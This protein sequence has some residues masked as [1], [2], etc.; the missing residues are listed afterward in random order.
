[1]IILKIKKKDQTKKEKSKIKKINTDNLFRFYDFNKEEFD[2]TYLIT[3]YIIEYVFKKQTEY[4]MSI[5]NWKQQLKHLL[6]FLRD[7]EIY[8]NVD[9]IYSQD[10]NFQIRS[11]GSIILGYSMARI[12]DKKEE[13]I[14]F[15]KELIGNELDTSK[16]ELEKIIFR[17]E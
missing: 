2:D 11:D 17:F 14:E 6:E 7:V 3:S 15:L 4:I 16:P 1:M 9:A 13:Y 10:W 8:M 12:W 5:P